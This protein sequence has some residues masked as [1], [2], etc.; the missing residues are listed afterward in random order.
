[1]DNYLQ[2][3]KQIT[4]VKFNFKISDGFMKS[5]VIFLINFPL[6]SHVHSRH[7]SLTQ[8][9]FFCNFHFLFTTLESSAMYRRHECFPLCNISDSIYEMNERETKQKNACCT[10]GG[11]KKQRTKSWTDGC[12]NVVALF[13]SPESRPARLIQVYHVHKTLKTTNK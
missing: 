3:L 11:S 13:Q 6:I 2:I 12:I 7:Q 4:P 8:N 9:S 1:M 10:L 5:C